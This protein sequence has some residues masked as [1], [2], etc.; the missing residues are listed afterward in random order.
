MGLSG[1]YG[2]VWIAFWAHIIEMV[3]YEIN[4]FIK[5]IASRMEHEYMYNDL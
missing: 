3:L 2:G 1:S 4:M 5:H